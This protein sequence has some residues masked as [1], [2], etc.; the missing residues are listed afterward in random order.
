MTIAV[1]RSF[2]VLV[3]LIAVMLPSA[4]FAVCGSPAGNEGDLRYDS[5][6]QT[7]VFCDGT[8]WK[9]LKAAGALGGYETVVGQ[10][11]C[12]KGSVSGSCSGPC[13]GGTSTAT[14]PSGKIGFYHGWC[15]T[16]WN[17]A[18]NPSA[19]WPTPASIS[20]GTCSESESVTA[21]LGAI[22]SFSSSGTPI[23][24]TSNSYTWANGASNYNGCGFAYIV[25]RDE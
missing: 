14:C 22:T 5:A 8:S 4:A 24:K 23:V 17:G 15:W 3:T 11:V 25:C 7:M 21:N 13:G 12:W 18:S 1:F 16:H 2:H 9:S 6:T 19:Q 10:Q 20:G